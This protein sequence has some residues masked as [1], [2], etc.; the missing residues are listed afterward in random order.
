VVAAGDAPAGDAPASAAPAG[1]ASTPNPITVAMS[2][3]L[4]V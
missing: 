4:I 2:A 3:L 1:D